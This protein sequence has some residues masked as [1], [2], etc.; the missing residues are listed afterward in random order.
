MRPNRINGPPELRFWG[1]VQGTQNRDACWIWTG[2]VHRKT[3]YGQF[4]PQPGRTVSAHRYAWDCA[5]GPIPQGLCVLHRC[6][7]KV[8]VNPAHLFL[9]TNR[10]NTLDMLAK[11]RGAV[12]DRHPARARGDYLAR[13]EAH[14]NAK[15]T[16]QRV[17]EIRQLLAEGGMSQKRIADLF[18]VSQMTVSNIKQGKIWRHV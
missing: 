17:G 5:N 2:S 7:N 13:G 18:G 14:V 6:D 4:T 3:G 1:R 11:G 15:L 8:C 10:D 16:A 12:G 9:G